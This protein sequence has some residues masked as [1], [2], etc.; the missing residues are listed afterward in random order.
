MIPQER[1]KL[2]LRHRITCPKILSCFWVRDPGPMTLVSFHRNYTAFRRNFSHT[3]PPP[4]CEYRQGSK[5]NV[6]FRGRS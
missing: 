6:E 4:K 5:G 2:L 3:D 1:G